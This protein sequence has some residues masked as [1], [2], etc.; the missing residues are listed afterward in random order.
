MNEILV[1]FVSCSDEFF[2][3]KYI[4]IYIYIYIYSQLRL[5]VV[6][7][8]ESINFMMQRVVTSLNWRIVLPCL[9]SDYNLGVAFSWLAQQL[10]RSVYDLCSQ[11]SSSG[12]AHGC[13]QHSMQGL[14]STASVYSR[15]TATAILSQ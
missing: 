15:Q 13:C 5:S 3:L 14:Y 11:V 7:K 2:F 12:V 8:L 6:Y 9:I 10:H 1:S 4:Y